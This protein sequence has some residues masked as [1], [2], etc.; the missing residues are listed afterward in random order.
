MKKIIAKSMYT[1]KKTSSQPKKIFTLL[2]LLANFLFI[3]FI[4]Y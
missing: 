4:V 1:L 2:F 3:C